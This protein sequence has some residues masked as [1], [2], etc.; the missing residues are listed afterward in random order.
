MIQDF[1]YALRNLRRSPLFTIIAM[2]SLALGIGANSAIFTIADQVLLR[3]LPVKHAADLVLF[4]SD[5][6]QTGMVWGSNRFSYPMFQDFRDHSPVL[7]GV[8]A[9]FNTP[10]SVAFGTHSEQ[11]NAE[12]VSGTYF[13][14][15]GLGTVLGRGLEPEDDRTPGGHPVA[16]LTYD[17]W[18]SHFGAN[19]AVLNQT[20]RVN[21]YPLTVVGVAAPGYRGFDVGE[22][23]D[24]LVPTMMKAQMTPTWNGL[25][26]RRIIWLQLIGRLHPGV[27][28]QQARAAL[29]PYY[30]SLLTAELQAMGSRSSRFAQ[31]FAAKPLIFQPALRGVSDMRDQFAAPLRILLAIVGLLLLIACANVA[32]LLLAR[33]AARQKEIAVRLALGAGRFRLARQLIVE[34]LALSLAGGAAGLLLAQWTAGALLG[35]MPDSATLGLTAHIDFRVF[36]FTA[37]LALASGLIF[38]L[39]PAWQATSPALSGTLKDQAGNV[40]PGSGHVRLRKALVT[41][42]VTLSLLMLI[43]ATLF[44][45]SLHNLKNVDLGFR[46]DRLLAFSL[47]PALN[48]YKTERTRALAQTVQQRIAAIPG[49]RSAAIAVNLVVSGNVDMSTVRVVGYQAKEDEDMNPYEDTVSPGYF[50]TMGIPLL[51][52]REFTPADRAGAPPVAIVNDAF[53]AYFFKNEDPLGRRFSFGR[54]KDKTIEI[55]GVVRGSK[56]EGVT[57][58]KVP[59]EVYVPFQ[60]QEAGQMVVYARA[61]ADPK[62]LFGALQREI[63]AL[64]PAL[65]VTNLRTMEE[66]VDQNL[67]A[68]RLMASLSAFFGILA[69]LLAAIGL[70]GVMAYMVT[71]RTREIGIRL[72]LGA[73]RANLLG[74][75]MREVAILTA[76]GV[77]VAVPVALALSRYVRAQL[78]GVAPTDAWSI[79]AASAVLI[80]TALLAGYIPAER[81]TRVSPT[82]A[83]RWE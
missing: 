61:S 35:L 79:L 11:V 68:Q 37:L 77:V 73:G 57:E 1:R 5:G 29:E 9:R 39:A 54:D 64:D 74:L 18:K 32:N 31:R 8:A 58:Q 21:E 16:V 45:R 42:Q 83:L 6:P 22:R 14:T 24:L 50:S 13:D 81:A 59:R 55:V 56:Y 20:I 65:P 10:L 78:Y 25:D 38:G 36:A 82:M 19:P 27:N 33:A 41:S 48:G 3:L 30:R 49:V 46:Q 28:A 34:S 53:A 71:R 72:A 44:A 7:A 12:L 2:L 69:T 52:G 47:N 62:A 17:F 63:A 75:V 15:L 76:A 40:S 60:Q 43:A 4:T 26:N 67:S 80:A 66:Q 70:Y 51:R 23:T